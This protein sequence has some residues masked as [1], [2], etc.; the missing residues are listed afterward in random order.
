MSDRIAL[1]LPSLKS[2]PLKQ[3]AEKKAMRSKVEV[4]D[5]AAR[6]RAIAAQQRKADE[7][8]ER[9]EQGRRRHQQQVEWLR[10]RGPGCG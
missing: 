3:L 6:E 4:I 9:L 8:A 10:K 1:A 2:V 5:S 7:A